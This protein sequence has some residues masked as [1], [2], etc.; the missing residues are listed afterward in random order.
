M[1]FRT[2]GLVFTVAMLVGCPYDR[3]RPPY[4][5]NKMNVAVEAQIVLTDGTENMFMLRPDDRLLYSADYVKISKVTF[6]S[7]DEV[8]DIL[9]QDRIDMMLK[10]TADPRDVTWYIESDGLRPSVPC[11]QKTRDSN[12]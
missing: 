7:D 8:I 2:A 1:K 5:E 12:K 10:C 3:L 6:I 4:F 11:R 9:D